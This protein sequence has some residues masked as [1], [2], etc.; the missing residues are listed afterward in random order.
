MPYI[1]EYENGNPVQPTDAFVI[2]RI[3]T[4]TLYVTGL[5]A[6]DL[7]NG[8]YTNTTLVVTNGVITSISSGSGIAQRVITYV[9]DGGG[10]PITTGVHG[11]LYLPFTVPLTIGSAS[12]LADQT[13]SC[14]IDIGEVA[15]ASYTGAFAGSITASDMP[16]LSS[17]VSYLDTTL[18]GWTKSVAAGSVLI[19]N[20]VSASTITRLTITLGASG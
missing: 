10:S 15:F 18:T 2:D 14:V 12:L 1:R 4:G 7:P 17:A 5:L 9:I 16:T 13:G 6:A 20:V 8:T 11:A 19:F 3:G